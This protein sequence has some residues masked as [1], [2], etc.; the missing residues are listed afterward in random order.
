MSSE[1]KGGLRK[2]R[3]VRC[4]AANCGNTN[5]NGVSMHFFPKAEKERRQWIKF[6]KEKRDKWDGPT[7]YSALCS[8]HFMPNCFPYRHHFEMQ[9]SGTKPKRVS[10]NPDAIP[11]IHSLPP[12]NDDAPGPSGGTKRPHLSMLTLEQQS[13]QLSPPKI[14]RRAYLK[15]ETSRV[16]SDFFFI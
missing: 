12:R 9:Q 13:G 2:G 6:V 3:G 8:A 15:R 7:Q 11:T 10:L 4:V 14:M 16:S 5:A 1:S